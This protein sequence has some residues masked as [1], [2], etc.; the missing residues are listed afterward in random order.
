[1]ISLVE[2]STQGWG[3]RYT[4]ENVSRRAEETTI[5]GSEL[6][7]KAPPPAKRWKTPVRDPYGRTGHLSMCILSMSLYPQYLL[8]SLQ[9][10][11]C[12]AR[13]GN[14]ETVSHGESV[15][16]LWESLDSPDTALWEASGTH[17]VADVASP[18]R[19]VTSRAH[20]YH[21]A[22]V[23]ILSNSGDPPSLLVQ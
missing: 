10:L 9:F 12:V 15:D 13:E 14:L 17:N 2:P 21:R 7:Y 20:T 6:A 23:L 8:L 19:C 16:T 11:L 3:S 5:L 22:T 4:R 1:M 18:P